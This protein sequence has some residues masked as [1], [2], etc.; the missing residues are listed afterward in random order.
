VAERAINCIGKLRALGP[1]G[2][3]ERGVIN[4]RRYI[5]RR[6]TPPC[7]LA[8]SSRCE[9]ETGIGIAAI[10]TGT[11][12][13]VARSRNVIRHF[14]PSSARFSLSP[15]SGTR[16]TRHS[17][18]LSLSS[19]RSVLDREDSVNRS[20]RSDRSDISVDLRSCDYARYRYKSTN[21]YDTHHTT[22]DVME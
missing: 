13:I 18:N 6:A 9:G 19:L 8:F 2:R 15:L 4:F 17:R 12:L 1:A 21:L 16:A 11:T 22:V 5:Y 3:E 14:L 7:I 20:N 10:G